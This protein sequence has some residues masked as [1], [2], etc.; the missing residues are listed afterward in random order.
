[1]AELQSALH[2]WGTNADRFKMKIISVRHNGFPKGSLNNR[3]VLLQHFLGAIF[4]MDLV[5]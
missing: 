2:H 3:D 1:M 5:S 4:M